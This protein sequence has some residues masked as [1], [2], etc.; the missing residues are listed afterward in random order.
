MEANWRLPICWVDDS[1]NPKRSREILEKWLK[2]QKPDAIPSD[3]AILARLLK[4]IG[5]R[6]P[7]DIGMAVT[8]VLDGGGDA[9]VDQEPMRS[10][11]LLCWSWFRSCETM[12]TG[13][14]QSTVRY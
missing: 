13:S 11:G 2:R 8:S 5:V 4:E 7:E 1:D 9:G 12:T 6:M 14:R 10:G 3:S